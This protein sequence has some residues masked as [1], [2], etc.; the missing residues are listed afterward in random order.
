MIS[1][2]AVPIG[3]VPMLVFIS[4][5][6]PDPIIYCLF[7]NTVVKRHGVYCKIDAATIQI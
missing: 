7:V 1:E 5:V 2:V 6:A 3:S 4:T